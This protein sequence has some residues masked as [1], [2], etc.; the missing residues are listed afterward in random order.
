MNNEKHNKMDLLEFVKKEIKVEH[1][2][3]AKEYGI[4]VSELNFGEVSDIIF[5]NNTLEFVFEDGYVTYSDSPN[6]KESIGKQF[7][8][9]FKTPKGYISSKKLPVL[10]KDTN[11]VTL[12]EAKE[13]LMF[14][15]DAVKNTF[16]PFWHENEAKRRNTIAWNHIAQ[17]L[18]DSDT[19]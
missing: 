16:D 14:N 19:F 6:E 4:S 9:A 7:T 5:K 1:E 17:N 13:L 18:S 11:N 10:V 3:I 8:C 15:T 12:E 2:A